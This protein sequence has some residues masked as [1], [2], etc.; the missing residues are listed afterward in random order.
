MELNYNKLFVMDLKSVFSY[1]NTLFE[2]N[3]DLTLFLNQISVEL[4][5]DRENIKNQ[6]GIQ[7][8][9]HS[10]IEFIFKHISKIEDLKLQFTKK[11]KMKKQIEKYINSVSVN[12]DFKNSELVNKVSLR[13]K[14]NILSL[15]TVEFGFYVLSEIKKLIGD[16]L[17]SLKDLYKNIIDIIYHKERIVFDAEIMILFI[18]GLVSLDLAK[19][20]YGKNISASKLVK[21]LMK[22]F[23]LPLPLQEEDKKKYIP[24]KKKGTEYTEQTLIKKLAESYV[25]KKNRNELNDLVLKVQEFKN[26]ISKMPYIK[27]LQKRKK[28][29]I[30]N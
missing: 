10:K 18:K 26:D 4:K 1:E 25:L 24:K 16:F 3:N 8:S 22:T 9:V 28:K 27:G 17:I 20:Q 11:I 23:L 14:F 12:P 7:K 21:I 2:S 6:I 5:N 29:K 30:Q 19:N 15:E 13:F